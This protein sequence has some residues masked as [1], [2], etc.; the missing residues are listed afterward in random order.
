MRY[1]NEDYD[2]A[3][4]FVNDVYNHFKFNIQRTKSYIEMQY[5]RC[6]LTFNEYLAACDYIQDMECAIAERSC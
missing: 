1:T 5:D 3:S 2:I 6:N 4:S